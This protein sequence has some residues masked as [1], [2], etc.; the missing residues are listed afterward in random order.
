M[1]MTLA[2]DMKLDSHNAVS[3]PASGGIADGGAAGSKVWFTIVGGSL[4]MAGRATTLACSRDGEFRHAS[5][6]K[7]STAHETQSRM[8]LRKGNIGSRFHGQNKT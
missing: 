2:S 4:L 1:A 5:Q 6:P 8:T 7:R 3:A